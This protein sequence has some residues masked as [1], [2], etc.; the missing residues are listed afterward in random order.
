M[1]IRP[2]YDAVLVEP[3]DAEGFV[4]TSAKLLIRKR[5]WEARL[6][7]V[8]AVGNGH[9]RKKADDLVPLSVT[10]G[11]VVLYGNMAGQEV[12]FPLI[13]GLGNVPA[14]PGVKYRMLREADILACWD[15]PVKPLVVDPRPANADRARA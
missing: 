11:D 10:V 14:V 5:H 12:E 1:T 4:E 7:R 13:E 6:A 3:L 9:K 2:L 8:V 15:G